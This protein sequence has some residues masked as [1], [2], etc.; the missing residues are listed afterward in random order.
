[1]GIGGQIVDALARE[2]AYKPLRGDALLIGK[3]TVYFTVPE[4]FQRLEEHGVKSAIDPAAIELDTSTIDRLPKYADR[5]LISD[6]SLMKLFGTTRVMALDHSAYEG[7]D[8]VQDLR[9][10]LSDALADSADILV[11]GSTLDNVFTPANVLQ[12]FTRLLRPGGRMFLC[13]AYS[14]FETAY[15]ILPPTWYLDYFVMNGFTDCRVYVCVFIEDRTSV[16]YVSLEQAYRLKREMGHFQSPHAAATLV[17][18]EKGLHSTWDRLPIQQ[19]YRS[20]EDWEIY[21]KNL[22]AMLVSQRPHLAR[23]VGEPIACQT[24]GGYQHINESFSATDTP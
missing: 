16:Y 23:T 9:R 15:V 11:D 19:H 6:I 14:S 18:A 4:M 12:N 3:Q 8:I 22:Q 20:K 1:M 7:A 21:Q 10:P 17:F 24:Q 13:N 2:H 5:K